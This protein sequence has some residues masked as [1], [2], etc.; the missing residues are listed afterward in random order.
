MESTYSRGECGNNKWYSEPLYGSLLNTILIIYSNAYCIEL[1][2]KQDKNYVHIQPQNISIKM[3]YA[4]W[5]HTAWVSGLM[6]LLFSMIF[7]GLGDENN[8][9]SSCKSM[10]IRNKKITKYNVNTINN[11]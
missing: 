10:V 11:P 3:K 9:V 4:D 6:A 2:R 1:N 5:N 7:M 8:Y